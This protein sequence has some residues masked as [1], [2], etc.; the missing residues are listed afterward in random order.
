MKLQETFRDKDLQ[1]TVKLEVIELI[2]ES[3]SYL[4]EDWHTDGLLSEHMVGT[5]V[6]FFDMENVS[7]SR[8]LFRQEIEINPGVYQFEEWDVPYLE[9]LFGVKDEK[10]ALQELGS[11]LVGQGLLIV[12][13]N[14]LHHRMEPFE[15]ISKSRA[16]HHRFLT[17][18]LVDPYYCICSTR[19]VPPQ[20]HAG[21]HK[22]HNH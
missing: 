5:A 13:P 16:E 20:R 21:G 4:G 10:P 17:P 1:I 2:L 12:F 3:L 18:W 8:L 6:Y 22:K 9:E 15:L 7:G 14:T 19:N 11:V